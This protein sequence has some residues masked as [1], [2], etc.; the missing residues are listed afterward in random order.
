MGSVAFTNYR[1]LVISL[2]RTTGE[3]KEKKNIAIPIGK[4][5]PVR[6]NF[7]IIPS[8]LGCYTSISSLIFSCLKGTVS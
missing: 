3:D 5:V 2:V 7:F 6:D 4:A 1:Y 8:K